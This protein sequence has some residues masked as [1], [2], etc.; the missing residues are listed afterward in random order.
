M[1]LTSF[2]ESNGRQIRQMFYLVTPNET[3]FASLGEVPEITKEV[4]LISGPHINYPYQLIFPGH[5]MAH[6]LHHLRSHLLLE[7]GPERSLWT[8]RF[9]HVDHG[10]LPS[11]HYDVMPLS[12]H[13]SP[14][15]L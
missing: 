12:S 15:S 7:E 11:K 4:S 6:P 13:D 14:E 5:P 2:L 1:D 8:E 10:G 3:S 9:H